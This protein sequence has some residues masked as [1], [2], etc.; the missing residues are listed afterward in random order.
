MPLD[1]LSEPKDKEFSFGTLSRGH[2]NTKVV[3]KDFLIKMASP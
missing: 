1:Y 3:K 2:L